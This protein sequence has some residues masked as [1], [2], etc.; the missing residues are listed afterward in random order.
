MDFSTKKTL[1]HVIN[2]AHKSVDTVL[3]E[4]LDGHALVNIHHLFDK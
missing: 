4:K 2:N 1:L 3:V